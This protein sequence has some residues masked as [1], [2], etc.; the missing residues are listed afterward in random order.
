MTRRLLVVLGFV[1]LAGC[2]DEPRPALTDER[3]LEAPSAP[4]G[5]PSAPP[6]AVSAAPSAAASADPV[7]ALAGTWRG[8]YEAKVGSLTLEP[9]AS[10]KRWG[11]TGESGALGAGKV[12]LT[13]AITGEVRGRVE[14]ALGPGT[15]SGKAEDGAVRASLFP[16]D[17][18]RPA[19]M[20]GVLVGLHKGDVVKGELRAAGPDA[21]V[22][23]EATVELRRE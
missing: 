20:T 9:K 16:D 12:E 14:G 1:A 10:P 6:P 15:L 22:V 8:T 23:R 4:V 21:T 3:P 13:V 18:S 17:P 7:A 11:K 2:K 5:A 19:A